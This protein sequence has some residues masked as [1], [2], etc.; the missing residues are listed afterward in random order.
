MRRLTFPT[1]LFKKQLMTGNLPIAIVQTLGKTLP[2]NGQADVDL[3]I[4]YDTAFVLVM[5]TTFFPLGV[6]K[7]GDLESEGD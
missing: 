5:N 4:A 1:P 6:H 2:F 3:G 7:V